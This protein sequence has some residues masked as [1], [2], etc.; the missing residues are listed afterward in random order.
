MD[1]SEESIGLLLLN[2]S[3][4]HI[5]SYLLNHTVCVTILFFIQAITRAYLAIEEPR[6][7][8]SVFF[9]DVPQHSSAQVSNTKPKTIF[10]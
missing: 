10:P 5:T 9:L 6:F 1:L 8:A 7:R 3:Q 4:L 2:P